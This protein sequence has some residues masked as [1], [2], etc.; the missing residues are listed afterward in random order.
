MIRAVAVLG[1]GTMG[2]QMAAL[3]ASVGIDVLVLDVSAKAA[4]DG[5]DR[6]R[7]AKPDPYFTPD[8]ARRIQVAGFDEGLPRLA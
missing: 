8:A 5:V 4:R 1:A 3:F 7:K 6:L 2:A